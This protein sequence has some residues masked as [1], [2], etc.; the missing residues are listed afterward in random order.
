M[1]M[2]NSDDEFII[3]PI[4]VKTNTLNLL[5][6]INNVKSVSLV[7]SQDIKIIKKNINYN[8]FLITLQSL[9]ILYNLLF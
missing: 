7:L 8:Y 6:E 2:S 5:K 9:Y 3:E 4:I 1:E